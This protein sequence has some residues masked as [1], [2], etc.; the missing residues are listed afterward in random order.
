MV[1]AMSGPRGRDPVRAALIEAGAD[2][3][4]KH[5]PAKVSVRQVARE[6]GV[7]HGLVHRHFGSKDGLLKAVVESL[8]GDV[9]SCLGERSDDE[10]LVDLLG[11]LAGTGDPRYYRIVAHALLD[12]MDVTDLQDRFPVVERM[13]AAARR[14]DGGLR[15][16]AQVTG[17]MASGL[18]FLLFGEYIAEATGQSPEQVESS[19]VELIQ[20]V[21]R[22]LTVSR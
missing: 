10:T 18:G 5:G 3:F 20:Y 19:R 17:L 22:Q 4:S 15:P 9:E 21:V 11:G 7:N 8:R 14:G 16:E 6:A 2:L 1:P 13:L 12:G